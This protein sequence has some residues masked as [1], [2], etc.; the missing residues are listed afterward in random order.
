MASP[1]RT[2]SSDLL[3]PPP[4]RFLAD[5]VCP[6]RSKK[7]RSRVPLPFEFRAVFRMSRIISVVLDVFFS[8]ILLFSSHTDS[9][10]R[11]R[12]V[13]TRLY[14]IFLC[15]VGFVSGSVSICIIPRIAMNDLFIAFRCF[16][17][18]NLPFFFRTVRAS[19]HAVLGSCPVLLS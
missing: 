13:L 8:I 15:D 3:R 10:G 17:D 5:R 19:R 6:S 1:F 14:G 2:L 11:C 12:L 18:C 9:R 7:K 16:S 4:Y